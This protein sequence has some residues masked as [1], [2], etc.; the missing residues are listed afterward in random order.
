MLL[1][2][3]DE[4]RLVDFLTHDVLIDLVA[5]LL[6]PIVPQALLMSHELMKDVVFLELA[7]LLR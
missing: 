3:L 6:K 2:A 5:Y 4:L 7:V 1:S